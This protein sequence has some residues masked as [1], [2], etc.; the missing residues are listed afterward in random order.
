MFIDDKELINIVIHYKKMGHDYEAYTSRE[1]N[2]LKLKEDEKKA[3][4][5]V[6]IK[7]A[8]LSWGLYNELQE[9]A[10]SS[11]EDGE[12]QFNYKLYK[13]NRI[14]RMVREWDAKDKNGKLVPIN[15]QTLLSLSPIVAEAIVR[16][17]DEL[18]YVSEE[19]ENL[20]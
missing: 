16:A 15:D 13:E 11:R 5:I 9:S 3:Y 10:L 18:S 17:L 12:R 14:K 19:E 4:D 20:S 1:F 8:V 2:A 6:N 7:A